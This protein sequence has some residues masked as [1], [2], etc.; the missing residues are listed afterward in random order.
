MVYTFEE[1][2]LQNQEYTDKIN[3]CLRDKVVLQTVI[4]GLNN[5]NIH[6][7]ETWLRRTDIPFCLCISNTDSKQ[8][9]KTT[10]HKT[11]KRGRPKRVITGHK[12]DTHAHLQEL[13]EPRKATEIQQ[14]QNIYWK[15]F[16]TKNKNVKQ[17]KSSVISKIPQITNNFFYSTGQADSVFQGNDFPSEIFEDKPPFY[18]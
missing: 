17:Q 8:L 16:R 4:S 14:K 7:I 2:L 1:I 15:K 12:V 18:Y 3:D 5:K 9:N 11:G 10:I 6:C 13:I